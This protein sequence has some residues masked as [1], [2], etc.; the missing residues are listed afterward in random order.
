MLEVNEP[1]LRTLTHV[2][3]RAS[4]S[5]NTLLDDRV[6]LKEDFDATNDTRHNNVFL[7]R[8]KKIRETTVLMRDVI[9]A[10]V[11]LAQ[12]YM[13]FLIVPDVLGFTETDAVTDI[14]GAGFVAPDVVFRQDA[15]TAGFVLETSP[16]AGEPFARSRQITV[17]ISRA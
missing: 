16:V 4:N 17:V 14:E 13:P 12:D 8:V 6:R 2:V 11:P 1:L 7:K 10:T 5:I 15:G 9:D 3:V